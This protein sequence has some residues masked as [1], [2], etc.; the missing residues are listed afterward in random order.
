[1]E[2][3][4]RRCYYCKICA[5]Y[6]KVRHYDKTMITVHKKKQMTEITGKK[7]LRRKADAEKQCRKLPV[8]LRTVDNW[9]EVDL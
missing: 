2:N 7:D 1:M 4:L 8:V 3:L 6:C 9:E 5:N